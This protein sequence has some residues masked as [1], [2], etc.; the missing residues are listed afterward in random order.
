MALINLVHID[1]IC[2]CTQLVWHIH[3]H[4]VSVEFEINR[5]DEIDHID[6][7][8]WALA[9]SCVLYQKSNH[10]CWDL[11]GLAQVNLQIWKGWHSW[12]EATEVISYQDFIYM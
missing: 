2:F 8:E 7:S 9:R 10:N 4:A 6:L 12:M 1:T 5:Y 3:V 11:S